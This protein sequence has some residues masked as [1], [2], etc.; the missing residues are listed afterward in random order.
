MT[1]SLLFPLSQ[2]TAYLVYW[3]IAAT[4]GSRGFFL[5]PL[6]IWVGCSYFQILV[7]WRQKRKALLSCFPLAIYSLILGWVLLM[8]L[9]HLDIA[10]YYGHTRWPP[11]WYL[12]IFPLFSLLVNYP[13]SFLNE[14]LFMTFILGGLAGMCSHGMATVLG[15]VSI[16]SPYAYPFVF[17]FWGSY[18]TSLIV[19]NRILIY[20]TEKYTD[21]KELDRSIIVLFDKLCPICYREMRSLQRRKQTGKIEY[22]MPAS[23]EEIQQMGLNISYKEAMKSIHAIDESGNILVGTE[24]LA[25]AYA[26]TNLPFLAVLLQAPGFRW[27]F[28][29]AYRVWAKMRPRGQCKL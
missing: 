24:A 9:M 16:T 5:F 25:A 7:L 29:R 22:K 18:L 23:D 13:L 15:A 28:D 4:L 14:R 10:V 8:L 26:R 11:L 6:I 2:V 27:F 1:P 21:P 19:L 12:S 20:L 3:I 17:L